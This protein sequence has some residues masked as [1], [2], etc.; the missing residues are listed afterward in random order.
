MPGLSVLAPRP[1]SRSVWEEEV[2]VA[3]VIVYGR[4]TMGVT[5]ERR[6]GLDGLDG[7]TVRGVELPGLPGPATAAHPGRGL[8]AA[9]GRL[10]LPASCLACG[11]ALDPARQ[12]LG[13]CLPCRGR[14]RV[15]EAGCSVCGAPL[16]AARMR[17]LTEGFVC[18]PCRARPPA[19][20]RLITRW[21]YD[22][23]MG[24]VVA[25][26]K[27][28]RLDYLGSHL[29]EGL[30]EALR[31]SYLH[32]PCAPG[33]AP[34]D[35]VAPVPLHWRRRI[36]RGFNQA[37]RIARPLARALGV[38]FGQPLRRRRATRAQARLARSERLENPVGAFA[39]AGRWAAGAARTGVAGRSVLLVDDVV[40][41][42]ATLN[43]AARTL[44]GAGAVAVTVAAVARTATPWEG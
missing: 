25:G 26:L 35:L 28:R 27:Y 20:D 4:R 42:G 41:T 13:L 5:R 15:P 23:P 6:A 14:L 37:E 3:F 1:G 24:A 32:G 2:A 43:A 44:V 8:L 38:P 18:G 31:A 7:G 12:P 36:L 11:R 17:E 16:P 21:R 22:G 9:I 34:W 29:A 39:V 40:T 10:L 30:L 33:A 19:Y